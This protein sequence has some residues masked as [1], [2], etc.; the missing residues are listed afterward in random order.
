MKNIIQSTDAR[1]KLRIGA[2]KIMDVVKITLGP[3]GRNVVLDRKYSTPLI[4]N[5]GVTIAREILLNDEFENMGCKLIKEVCQKTNDDAGDGT[6]TAIVLAGNM[7][8]IGLEYTSRGYNP[9]YLNKGIDKATKIAVKYLEK[10]S[11]PIK[12]LSDIEN[13][14]TISSNDEVVGRLI[15]K[16]YA[17]N[18]SCNITLLDSK[19]NKT[20]LVRQDGM[21]INSG[22]LSSYLATNT[23]KGIAEYDNPYVLITDKKINNF[24]ELLGIFEQLIKTTRPLVIICDDIDNEA[25]STI[26][27]N[28][29]R[30]TF[31][32]CV[33]RAPLYGD[34]KLAILEDISVLTNTKTVSSQKG[35]S[36]VDITLQDLGEAKHIKITKDKTIIISNGENERL[37]QRINQVKEQIESCDIDYDKEQLKK[38]LSNLTGGVTSILVG[39]S[40]DIEQKEKKLR[41]E[42]AISATSSALT[43]GVLPGGGVSLYKCAK[44]LEKTKKK[45]SNKEELAGFNIVIKGLVSPI[46]QILDNAGE[47]TNLIL[48]KINSKKSF[49]FGFDAMHSKFGNLYSFGIIDPA[50]VS[51][52]AIFNASSVVKTM[53][54]TEALVSDN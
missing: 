40:T 48:K 36:L 15:K 9:V 49:N 43:L 4:T 46:N 20:E 37:A 23:D 2:K 38:R 5:D 27:I 41:I 17:Y 13:I 21:T 54:T 32:A 50:K 11:R 34:K 26:T 3:K 7:L 28:V 51:I 31:N 33:I 35:M 25:L 24:N 6:T 30:K 10:N 16:A 29:L 1:E 44:F 39:A 42:D 53:L 19:T 12:D 8:D 14:A 47:N 18:N 52:S 45:I 22:L